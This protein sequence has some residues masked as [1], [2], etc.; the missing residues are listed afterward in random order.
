MVL[1]ERKHPPHGWAIPGGFVEYG[2]TLEEAAR[3][4]ALEETSLNLED[5]KQFR[6]YSE[7]SRDPRGHTVSMVFTAR[8]VGSPKASSDAKTV[9]VFSREDL[10]QPMTFDHREILQDYYNA[11]SP[12]KL[13]VTI[14]KG[15][16][17][18]ANV[19]AIVVA[20]NSLGIMGGGVALAV[21]RE[22]GSETE[23]EARRRA[24]IPVGEAIVTSSGRTGFKGIIHAPT[25]E[26]PG[27]R[28]P[29]E[30]V[31]KATLASLKV[32]DASGF[33][34]L[35]IP[36]MGVGVGGVRREDAARLMLQAVRDFS[37]RVLQKVLLI[38][39]DEM[40]VECWRGSSRD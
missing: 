13:N 7:P 5:L 38:D 39:L 19:D 9:G 35:A 6:A 21:R 31:Y 29:P 10:P 28:I 17:L 40:M 3:R 18:E 37:P 12:Q 22:A 2:E 26:K 36:G 8:G 33:Q 4:E 34:S 20:A 27:L 23:D 16:I 30:N 14:Q 32:A 11:I 25:M 24:P 15:T 1:V